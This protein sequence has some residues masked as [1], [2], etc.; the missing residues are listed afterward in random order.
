LPYKGEY[1]ARIHDPGK[2]DE[3]R[4]KNGEFGEGVDV[5][6]GI[7]PGGKTEVQAIRFKT[8]RFKSRG[9]V[10]SWLEKHDYKSTMVE[11]PAK[12]DVNDDGRGDRRKKVTRHDT[13]TDF[14]DVVRTPSGF[15]R[16]RTRV[17]RTGVYVY[18]NPDGTL[19]RELRHPEDVFNKDSLE[20]LKMIPITNLH[21]TSNEG[22]VTADT[23]QLLSIGF[24]G[25]NI[26]IDGKFVDVP[27][28]ITSADGVAA[29]DGG[30][31]ELSLGYTF[32]REEVPGTF[33]G[34]VY[35]YR[36]RNIVYNHLAIV[37]RGRA[38]AEV[39]LNM[40]GDVE[41]VDGIQE[42]V[43]HDTNPKKKEFKMDKVI[44]SL[45]GGLQYEVSP[46]VKHYIESQKVA[47]DAATTKATTLESEVQ[48]ITGERD[49]AK[50]ELKTAQDAAGPEA[51]QRAVAA[52]VKLETVALDFLD[53]TAGKTIPS[54]SDLDVKKLVIKTRLPE[55]T[56][57]E[58]SSV[59]YVDGVF[60]T[61]TSMKDG[62][63]SASSQRRVVNQDGVDRGSEKTTAD[64][65]KAMMDRMAKG[66][67]PPEK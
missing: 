66:Y 67:L 41:V 8:S 39:R 29:V 20:S 2:Y 59:E 60:N 47:L 31:R 51:I 12:D 34:E 6:Y 23:A 9:Q 18:R 13:E 32:E 37:N 16:G 58:K 53:E 57:D 11:D 56:L 33:D 5:L 62:G 49:A 14:L 48:K 46:E 19:R 40:D 45:D 65:R 30:R 42:N 52:R 28:V 25:E 15:L 64:S 22:L 24:T 21:P 3:V 55:I 7:L 61:V 1:A 38:G 4:R 27:I 26:S 35:D 10:T 54:L 17:T 63:D 36:Q 43:N 44:V 50:A